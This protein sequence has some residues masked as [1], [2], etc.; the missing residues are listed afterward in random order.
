MGKSLL[1]LPPLPPPP[2]PPLPLLLR[3]NYS[4]KAGEKS[5]DVLTLNFNGTKLIL[6]KKKKKFPKMIFSSSKRKHS[7]VKTWYSSGGLVIE[8]LAFNSDNPSLSPTCKLIS[9]IKGKD[10]KRQ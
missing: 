8:V 5:F 1:P 4:M 7:L 6:L 3:H 10:K 9:D 2:L